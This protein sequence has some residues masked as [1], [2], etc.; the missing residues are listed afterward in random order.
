VVLIYSL[1]PGLA[2]LHHVG[3]HGELFH[4]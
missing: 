3:S 4:R 2:V 1:P